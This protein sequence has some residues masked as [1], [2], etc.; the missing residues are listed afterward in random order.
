MV[1][2]LGENTLILGLG[3]LLLGDEGVG[4]NAA[5]A[6]LKPGCPEGV[7]VLDIG[8]AISDALPELALADR[9]I[10]VDTVKADQEPGS[11]Y[12]LPFDDFLRPT[13]IASMHGFNLSR[14]LALTGRKYSPE[15]LVL[16]VEPVSMDWSMELSP[17]VA[18]AIPAVLELI[19][20]EIKMPRVGSMAPQSP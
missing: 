19:W 8:T 2:D 10:V 17:E 20:E 12:R 3:N 13:C 15:V 18:A 4:V 11:V 9:V 14:I 7:T 1:T 5:R 16:G 6:L